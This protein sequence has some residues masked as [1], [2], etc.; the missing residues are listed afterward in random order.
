MSTKIQKYFIGDIIKHNEDN[1]LRRK[2]ISI[3]D[4]FY[5]ET[6]ISDETYYQTIILDKDNIY[7]PCPIKETA[8]DKYYTREIDEG[9]Q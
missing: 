4:I 1:T 5:D 2:I 9:I 3:Y 8:I 7:P 6:G